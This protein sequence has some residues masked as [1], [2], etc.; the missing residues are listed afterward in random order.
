LS[1]L[2][3]RTHGSTTG[4]K[5]MIKNH[6]K[7]VGATLLIRKILGLGQ[8]LLRIVR[9]P[10]KSSCLYFICR[11]TVL[12]ISGSIKSNP[13]YFSFNPNPC[14]KYSLANRNTVLRC[15]GCR[16]SHLRLKRLNTLKGR[17]NV[18]SGGYL[19]LMQASG[20]VYS[21]L[22]FLVHCACYP[23]LYSLF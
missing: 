20:G 4:L 1:R 14:Q 16:I 8:S 12:L 10:R 11:A 15:R 21:H 5:Q 6:S 23:K 7:A 17:I 2:E 9:D 13:K 22:Y 3:I 18:Y 19:A